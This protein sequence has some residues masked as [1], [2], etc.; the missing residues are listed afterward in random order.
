MLAKAAVDVRN[1]NDSPLCQEMAFL[2]ES[3]HAVIWAE[4]HGRDRQAGVWN[5]VRGKVVVAEETGKRMMA[6]GYY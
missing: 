4:M 2:V 6:D 1:S 3:F 5:R